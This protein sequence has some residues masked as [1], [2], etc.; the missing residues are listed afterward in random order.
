MGGTGRH[1]RSLSW[2]LDPGG[3]VAE[4][5]RA[6]AYGPSLGKLHLF[7]AHGC[8]ADQASCPCSSA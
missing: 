4:D 7:S 6:W 5:L 2:A 1:G 8:P 3:P